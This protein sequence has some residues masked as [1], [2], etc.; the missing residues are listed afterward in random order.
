[1]GRAKVQLLLLELDELFE[2]ELEELFEELLELAFDDRLEL[3]LEELLEDRFEALLELALDELFEELLA[4]EFEE[5]LLLELEELFEELLD[6]RFGPLRGP[7]WKLPPFDELFT[8]ELDE[9]LDERLPERAPRS[10]PRPTALA[11]VLMPRSQPLKKRCTGVGAK[12]LSREL[13]RLLRDVFERSSGACSRFGVVWPWAVGVSWPS[14]RREGRPW[15]CRLLPVIRVATVAAIRRS[16][17]F[18]GYLGGF[19]LKETSSGCLPREAR[20]E[21][22]VSPTGSRVGVH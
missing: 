4:L 12:L 22:P 10:S 16:L 7:P 11:A 20:S 15:A 21:E 8:L 1:V 2:L 3:L 19:S 6:D 9:L 13:L 14:W 18:M 5:P 17:W